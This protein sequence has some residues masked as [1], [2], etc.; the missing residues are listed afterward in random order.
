VR[1]ITPAGRRLTAPGGGAHNAAI[2]SGTLVHL[3]KAFTMTDRVRIAG[4]VFADKN[5]NGT[6]NAGENGIQNA[7]VYRDLNNNGTFDQSGG[8]YDSTDVPKPIPDVSQTE[9][10]LNVT[11]VG[12]ILSMTV[13]MTITHTWAADVDVWLISPAGTI[14]ELTTDNGSSGDHYINTVF[15]DAAAISITAGAPPFTG[16]YRPEQPL[17]TLNGQSGSGTWRLRVADDEGAITGTLNSWSITLNATEPNQMTDANG[18]YAFAALDPGN[19]VVRE[20]LPANHVFTNPADGQQ[21]Y[22]AIGGELL[23][24]D[25]GNFATAYTGQDITLRLDPTG[26][27]VQIWVDEPTLGAPTY[28]ADKDIL[29]SLTFTGTAG[30]DSFTLDL[31]NGSPLSGIAVSYDG[32]ANAG[33]GDLFSFKGSAAADTVTFNAGSVIVNGLTVTTSN[34]ERGRF[35][36]RDGSDVLNVNAGAGDVSIGNT[37]HL[38]AHNIAAGAS[39]SVDLGANATIVTNA[40]SIAG[41]FNLNDNDLILFYG[42]AGLSPLPTVQGLINTARNGGAWDGTSG[43]MS[44]AAKNASPRNTTLGAM[45][46]SDFKSI[47]GPSAT[48]NGEAL[49]GNAVLVKYTYYGDA[50]FNGVVNFDDY[51]RTDAGFNFGRSGWMNGDFDGNGV[52]NFD[53]YSLIDLAFNTQTSPLR[54]GAESRGRG[55]LR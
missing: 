10:V 5:G 42:G 21:I 19:H 38:A 50:D 14:I 32:L 4:R 13:K 33:L 16:S 18:A 47:Y 35:D 26:E 1:A 48:F 11:G 54:V 23:T 52:V 3:D 37:Q 27:N 8:T 15:D 20:Q 34:T 17:S 2:A 31:A 30:D 25:F 39:A 9:S 29:P 49:A 22:N 24:G 53:D 12:S 55:K 6:L 46:A 40:M 41:L 45:E 36:G 44:T 43:L 7:R 51:S 28:T